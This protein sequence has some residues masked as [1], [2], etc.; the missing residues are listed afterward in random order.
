M[1]MY[2][3]NGVPYEALCMFAEMFSSR[4]CWP[5]NFTYPIV[6]KAC[7]DLSLLSIGV[8]V[9]GKTLKAGLDLNT[10]MQNYLLSM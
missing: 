5:N 4:Q 3:Q 8:V 1:R 2:I 10:F 7:G 9:H 6:I